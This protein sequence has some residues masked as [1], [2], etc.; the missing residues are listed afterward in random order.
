MY[1]EET[2]NSLTQDDILFAVNKLRE[3]PYY[4][5]DFNYSTLLGAITRN[6]S[7]HIVAARSALHH[8][9]TVVDLDNLA[10]LGSDDA[11]TDPDATLDDVNYQ[12][13]SAVIDTSLKQDRESE[14][15]GVHVRVRMTRSFTDVSSSAIFFDMKR[16]AVCII[17]MYMYTSVMLGRMDIIEQRFYLTAAG[18]ASIALGMLVSIGITSAMGLSLIHI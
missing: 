16:V 4:G 9:I 15:Q 10:S 14:N 12:W 1:H 11:G 7:G 17:I 8:Y 3:S 18:I 13:Q 6:S 2:V 5:Y